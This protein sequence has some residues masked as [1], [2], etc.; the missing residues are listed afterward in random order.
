VAELMRALIRE[1][2]AVGRADGAVLDDALADVLVEGYRRAPPDSINS[3]HAD[4]LAGRPM[5]IAARNGAIV[6]KGIAHGIP[7][8]LNQAIVT[9]LSAVDA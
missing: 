5:E 2:I 1:C 3:L 7:T 6:R 4:R 8:P 9:L